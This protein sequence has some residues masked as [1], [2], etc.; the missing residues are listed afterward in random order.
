MADLNREIVL[1]S[2]PEGIPG[3][4]NFAVTDV[5]SALLRRFRSPC[6]IQI[7]TTLGLIP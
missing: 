5:R 1:K 4:D 6:C 3:F 2:R 7:T